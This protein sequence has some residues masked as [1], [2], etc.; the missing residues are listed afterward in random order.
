M[1]VNN[2]C[3]DFRSERIFQK[4]CIGR[5]KN[6]LKRFARDLDPFLLN[7]PSELKPE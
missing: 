2:R 4:K 5:K 3:A 1:G 6:G 7:F